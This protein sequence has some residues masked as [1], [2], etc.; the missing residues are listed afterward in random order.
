MADTLGELRQAAAALGKIYVKAVEAGE[1]AK[2]L[3]CVQQMI[4][5]VGEAIPCDDEFNDAHVMILNLGF[6]LQEVAEGRLDHH[7]ILRGRFAI[8][9]VGQVGAIQEFQNGLGAAVML[10]LM[11]NSVSENAAAHLVSQRLGVGTTAP[12]NWVASRTRKALKAAAN[13]S[14]ERIKKD[15]ALSSMNDPKRFA[16]QWLREQ[17]KATL[18]L[19]PT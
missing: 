19:S 7:P 3:A 4:V 13:P 8:G 15:F 9:G 12:K 17:L 2:A 1:D 14:L 6:A 10:F 11:E 16:D 18:T 5:R